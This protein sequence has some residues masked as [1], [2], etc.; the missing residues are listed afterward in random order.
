MLAA[1]LLKREPIRFESTTLERWERKGL[2]RP[3]GQPSEA[4]TISQ[5]EVGW[6]RQAWD[7]VTDTVLGEL[8]VIQAELNSRRGVTTPNRWRLRRLYRW[9]QRHQPK[10]PR[11]TY[12]DLIK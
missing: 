11:E 4:S 6:L 1:A 7:K 5:S 9:Q 10:G 3:F 12:D 2:L 8:E